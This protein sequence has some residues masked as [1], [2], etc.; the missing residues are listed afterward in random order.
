VLA[1]SADRPYPAGK[2]ALHRSVLAGG[3]ALSELGPGAAVHR[4][5]FLARN[6]LIAALSAMTVVVEA[7]ERSGSLITARLAAELE[8]PVG[9]VPGRISSPQAA[10]PNQLLAGG[11]RV[12]RGVQD[13]LETLAGTGITLAQIELPALCADLRAPLSSELRELLAAIAD[14]N[15]SV[16]TLVRSD[17]SAERV[18]AA[19]A[20][21]ELGGYVRRVSGG[22]YTV[23]L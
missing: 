19:I 17:A 18:L 10:G 20:A 23:I 2:L 13:V 4:W 9:A 11:A 1:G 22:R 16:A 21:L 14:G 3:A 12:I 8:R 6:R 5:A 7:G 15:D